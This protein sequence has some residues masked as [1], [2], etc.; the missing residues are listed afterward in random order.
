M[1]EEAGRMYRKGLQVVERLEESL[2]KPPDG[3]K[4]D[5]FKALRSTCREIIER[6]KEILVL[7]KGAIPGGTA[8]PVDVIAPVKEMQ[9]NLAQLATALLKDHLEP[10]WKSLPADDEIG[11]SSETP[12]DSPQTRKIV[13]EIK[14]ADN[15]LRAIVRGEI[16]AGDQSPARDPSTL[17]VKSV[18][19]AEELVACVYATFITVVLLRIRWLVFSAVMIYTAI[20]FSSASYPFQ[21]AAT[22]RT[23]ALLL[24]LLGGVVVGYVYE[25]MHRNETLRRITSTDPNKIDSALW[26]KVASAGLLPLLGLLSTLFPQIGHFLYS[27]A[28]PILQATR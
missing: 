4:P 27:L 23:L 14:E 20:V 3:G 28:A 5:P 26:L 10:S 25:E 15:S 24:F 7:L 9:E 6:W 19:L 18:Q 13:A 1:Q 17:P 11:S 2:D 21:P 8:K 12:Q 16:M 22:L